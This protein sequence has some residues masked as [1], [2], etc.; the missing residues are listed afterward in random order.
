VKDAERGQKGGTCE[1]REKEKEEK[2]RKEKERERERREKVLFQVSMGLMGCV[3]LDFDSQVWES[4]QAERVHWV[5]LPPHVRE[6]EATTQQDE[7]T[8]D[9]ED[10]GEKEEEDEGEREEEEMEKVK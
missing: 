9:E 8:K 6:R 10:E 2:E 7:M 3:R 5:P 4:A 1:W